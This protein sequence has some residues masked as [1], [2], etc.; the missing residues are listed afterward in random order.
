M[1]AKQ[2]IKVL[3]VDDDP[4]ILELN[5]NLLLTCDEV[6]LIGEASNGIQAIEMTKSLKPDVILMDVKMPIMSGIVAAEQIQLERPTPIIILTGYNDSE[7][8]TQSQKA[9]VVAYLKKPLDPDKIIGLLSISIARFNDI[10]EL[11]RLNKSLEQEI[12]RRQAIEEK[13]EQLIKRLNQSLKEINALTGLLPI[14]ARCKKVRND[15]GY[16]QEVE[17]YIESHS[18]V[19]FSHGLCP[20]C[21]RKLYPDIYKEIKNDLE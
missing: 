14:C 20:S 21:T 15:Q 11:R 3:M 12:E 5:R 7:L 16:W 4:D 1:V 9:G 10:Q 17:Q 19:E 6:E 2:K 8:I 18:T 13:N